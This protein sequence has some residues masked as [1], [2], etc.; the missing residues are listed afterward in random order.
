M[1]CAYV[2]IVFCELVVEVLDAQAGS[3]AVCSVSLSL[4]IRHCLR[5]LINCATSRRASVG[6]VFFVATATAASIVVIVAVMHPVAA[7]R[8]SLQVSESSHAHVRRTLQC[9]RCLRVCSTS[10]G[11]SQCRFARAGPAPQ[12]ISQSSVGK[13]V[14]PELVGR[15]V[16]AWNG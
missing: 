4:R 15:R 14:W 11:H 2:H 3:V 5:I 8:V 10:P 12:S 6:A 7:T 1:I 13:R 9:L 16:R